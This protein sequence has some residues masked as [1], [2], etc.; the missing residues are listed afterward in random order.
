METWKQILRWVAAAVMVLG[1][2][3]GAR[4]AE[5]GGG[6][7]PVVE[8]VRVEAMGRVPVSAE[9]VLGL[10]SA[11]A[12]KRLDRAEMSGDV[13]RLQESGMYSYAEVRLEEGV[14]GGVT[15]LYRVRGRP[16]IRKLRID[17]ADYLGNPKVRELM[18]IRSGSR[19]DDSVLGKGAEAVKA[20]YRKSYYPNVQVEW[21]LTP[22]EEDEGRVDVEITVKEGRRAVVRKIRFKGVKHVKEGALRDVIMQKESTWLSWITNDGMFE[23]GL[24][25]GDRELVRKALMDR[26][27]LGARVGEPECE[28]VG[29]K[30]MDITFTVE[31]GPLYKLE[32]WTLKGETLFGAEELSK[33]VTGREG[34]VA[35]MEEIREN[36]QNIR[37]H[38]GSRGY[39]R[40]GVTPKVELDTNA[41][42][43][44]VT[45][46]IEEGTLAYI[47]NIDIRGNTRTKDKV[48]RREIAV[49]PGD[50]YNEKRVRTSENRVRNLNYFSYVGTYPEPTE[51][52][53][54]YDLVMEVEEQ[55]TGM[56][57][58]GVGFS[59]VDNVVGYAELRQGNFDLLGGLTKWR[60]TGGGQK[61]NVRG[62]LGDRRSDVEVSWTE[63][64]FLDKR[65]SLG[66]DLFRR[67]ASYYSDD[68]DQTTTGG[69]VT[70]G[71]AF[72]PY[73]R[74]N[75]TYGLEDIK[76]SDVSENASQRIKDEE[77]G[78]LKSY[79]QVELVRDTRDR[80][81]LPTRGFR[82][83]VAA[84]LAGGPFGGETDTYGFNVRVAQHFPLWFG[85]VLSFRGAGATVE[86]YGD[87]TRVPIFDRTFMGGP[88]TV[89][90]FKYHKVGPKD[91][92]KEA[93]GG[94]S[95]A[96]A[97]AEYTFPIVKMIRGAVFYDGGIVWQGIFEKE[98][99]EPAVGDGVWCDGYGIGI[100]FDIPQF[101]I[102]L[103]YA[104]P[105]E[106]DDMLG[107]H[108]RFSFNIGYTY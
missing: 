23:P 56:L 27:Y 16:V 51:E 66:V 40:T 39:I 7:L 87:S 101:P 22:V 99:D 6:D 93:L 108:G 42:T 4:G 104:W 52:E 67:E 18:E 59:S 13:R 32:G 82:G 29:K 28:Y 100:R 102:Q 89:R 41:A 37:D 98:E 57:T 92:N 95:S 70:L 54:Q 71:H 84:T 44:R 78:R 79:G 30:K 60:W 3:A 38:Y 11:R 8:E 17:G 62:Q 105:I 55:Q 10:V 53:G 64:W 48:I 68:Y 86:E 9:Q 19:V 36:A 5:A 12:G 91:E 63:P 69:A 107:T 47:R 31:E 21:T 75:W 2:G 49:A 83:S 25:P 90:A 61:F 45:Y 34:G 58:F 80:V 33:G 50:V 65:L 20:R 24:L 1:A 26:G 77:G 14:T 73:N 74:L 76:I 106:S 72:F 97:S 88:R 46:E 94:R 43:A 15:L 85:H 96:Y 103:D 81:F 35:A